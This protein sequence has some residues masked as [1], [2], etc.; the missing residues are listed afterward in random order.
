MSDYLG[1]SEIVNLT[2]AKYKSQF[3]LAKEKLGLVE[4]KKVDNPYVRYGADNEDFIIN[5]VEL[6]GYNFERQVKLRDDKYKLSGV[7]D[8]ID[9]SKK[10][11]LEVKTYKNNPSLQSYIDQMNIYFYLFKIDNGLLATY[12]MS[13]VFNKDDIEI[14][15]VNKSQERLDY[16]F[17]LIEN[18]WEKTEYLKNNPTITK[19]EFDN[20]K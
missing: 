5:A 19:K 12:Q 10:I 18:F 4:V 20:L 17:E 3:I 11:I 6:F 2:E 1:A 8:G 13:N 9:Y 15:K 7:V 14:F 16:L